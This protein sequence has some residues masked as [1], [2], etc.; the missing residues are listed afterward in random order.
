MRWLRY[1]GGRIEKEN[2]VVAVLNIGSAE[3]LTHVSKKV[4]A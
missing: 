3:A 2:A 4:P 1:C